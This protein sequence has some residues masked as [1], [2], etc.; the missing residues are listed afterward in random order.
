MQLPQERD[1]DSY[2]VTLWYRTSFEMEYLPSNT[3]LLID[4]FS[5]EQYKLFVNG[6]ELKDRG[7]R[8]QLDAEIK[9]VNIQPF[10]K[11]GRNIVTVK[12]IVARRTDG[13]L[14][15][16]KIIGDFALAVENN[17]YKIV[18]P[19]QAI[20]IGDWTQQGYPFYSGTGVYETESD[21]TE[22]YLNGKLF[23]N[24][25]CGEDVLEMSINSSH[26]KIVPW[27]PYHIDVS[28]WIRA[29]KNK[30]VLQVTNTLINLLEAMQKKSGIFKEPCLRY[31][32][33]YEIPVTKKLNS[34]TQAANP[35]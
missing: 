16:L 23:L 5:G 28:D 6:N 30:I 32:N 22:S 18:A 21:V 26:S 20:E 7:K 14:D 2:P 17:G 10:L 9:E 3:R 33:R 4:G 25:D 15:L 11:K 1:E 29:G 13:I 27:H 12:L 31:M 24:V 35:K 19:K 8:S 34:K